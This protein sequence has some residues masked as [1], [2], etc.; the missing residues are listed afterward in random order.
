MLILMRD[1]PQAVRCGLQVRERKH[2]ARPCGHSSG[3]AVMAIAAA[4]VTAA[5][6]AMLLDY[7][8]V[9][10]VARKQSDGIGVLYVV[11]EALGGVDVW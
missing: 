8:H 11:L 10:G 3:N 9:A 5:L 4:A 7:T 6:I 1:A 2:F